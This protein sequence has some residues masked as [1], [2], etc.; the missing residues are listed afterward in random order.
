MD[1]SDKVCTFSKRR[2]VI[3]KPKISR[4]SL[5]KGGGAAFGGMTML[6]VTVPTVAFGRSDKEVIPWFDQP[7]PDVTDNLQP[8]EKLISSWITPMDRFFNVNHYG[9]PT[10][11]DEST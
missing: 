9:Q 6:R 7:P 11:L 10:S 1:V 3:K 2:Q 4:R 5:L 8:R